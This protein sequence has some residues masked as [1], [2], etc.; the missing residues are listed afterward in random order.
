MLDTVIEKVGTIGSNYDDTYDA[1]I[2]SLSST[3]NVEEEDEEMMEDYDE[4]GEEGEDY[5]EY[6]EEE[7]ADDDF[8]AVAEEIITAQVGKTM[9]EE[10]EVINP[11]QALAEQAK[12]STSPLWVLTVLFIAALG[13]GMWLNVYG[14]EQKGYSRKGNRDDEENEPIRLTTYGTSKKDKRLRD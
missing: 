7:G 1:I 4:E 2:S 5:E 13:Y 3:A 8:E 11:D 14:N 10:K 6:V 9:I 12:S